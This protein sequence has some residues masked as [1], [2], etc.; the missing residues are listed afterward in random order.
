MPHEPGQNHLQLDPALK[1]SGNLDQSSFSGGPLAR[2]AMPEPTSPDWLAGA[3]RLRRDIYPIGT[4]C[5]GSFT[6]VVSGP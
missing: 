1:Q 6:P 4:G 3:R 5:S 2:L